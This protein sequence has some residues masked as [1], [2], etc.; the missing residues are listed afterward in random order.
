MFWEA[1]IQKYSLS[2]LFYACSCLII[3][4]AEER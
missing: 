4:P 2:A 3:S 1:L